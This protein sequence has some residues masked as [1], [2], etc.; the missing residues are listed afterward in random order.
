[1]FERRRVVN[2]MSISSS[3]SELKE[4]LSLI[5]K[6]HSAERN[7]KKFNLKN[8]R[9]DSTR[10]L[11]QLQ[12]TEMRFDHFNEEHKKELLN[13]LELRRFETDFRDLQV[14]KIKLKI[15]FLGICLR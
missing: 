2:S 6:C 11:V 13:V 7:I 9:R 14:R 5:S 8:S 10:L 1:M 15:K 4:E 12:E 3:K